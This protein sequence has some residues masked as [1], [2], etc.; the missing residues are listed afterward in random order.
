MVT[1][2][3]VGTAEDLL[4]ACYRGCPDLV[5]RALKK[6]GVPPAFNHPPQRY[7][8]A[9]HK[10]TD[11]YEAAFM[12]QM[13]NKINPGLPKV[14][15]SKAVAD[16]GAHMPNAFPDVVCV[17]GWDLFLAGNMCWFGRTTATGL[18]PVLFAAAVGICLVPKH[19]LSPT[20]NHQLVL[21]TLLRAGVAAPMPHY[22]WHDIMCS[23]QL[24][25][26]RNPINMYFAAL[27][28]WGVGQGW[29]LALTPY[30]HLCTLATTY[31]SVYLADL[32]EVV[33]IADHDFDPLIH[34]VTSAEVA[35][36]A[37]VD[38]AAVL[39]PKPSAVPRYQH[40]TA[41][42]M[43]S[44][45][46]SHRDRSIPQPPTPTRDTE[47]RER[48]WNCLL[49]MSLSDTFATIAVMQGRTE[50]A[51]RSKYGT[52]TAAK[53]LSIRIAL[54][55]VQEGLQAWNTPKA[56]ATEEP[57]TSDS[58][59]GAVP[60]AGAGSATASATASGTLCPVFTAVAAVFP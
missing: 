4:V 38:V 46:L 2:K 60:V 18:H 24:A 27:A 36:V 25:P 29:K 45:A 30:R 51:L 31:D 28:L 9:V 59:P 58:S 20:F 21:D 49:H 19:G 48:L 50:A 10:C 40:G 43:W 56:A 44:L 53:E 17:Y 5:E 8:Q 34:M 52:K 39:L 55:V 16:E 42:T 54:R 1:A 14:S 33:D 12:E 57:G 11:T 6:L 41:D 26:G 23:M 35:P 37:A 22:L 3:D 47:R 13:N 7:F 32:L 15:L